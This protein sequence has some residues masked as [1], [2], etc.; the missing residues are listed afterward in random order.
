[1]VAALRGLLTASPPEIGSKACW[2]SIVLGMT[3]GAS[4][5]ETFWTEFLRQLARRGL[6]SAVC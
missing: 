4:E 1:M 6:P 2:P 5:A 3:I